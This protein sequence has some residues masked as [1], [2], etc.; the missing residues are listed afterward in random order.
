M[1]GCYRRQRQA[2]F[3]GTV[4]KG[5]DGGRSVGRGDGKRGWRRIRVWRA[6]ASRATC[7]CFYRQSYAPGNLFAYLPY[8]PTAPI[9]ASSKLRTACRAFVFLHPRCF[10][11]SSRSINILSPFFARPPRH[12]FSLVP[13]FTRS[14]WFARPFFASL[15][16]R[17]HTRTPLGQ[18]FLCFRLFR[19]TLNRRF[20]GCY[21]ASYC[22]AK[23]RPLLFAEM[24]GRHNAVCR[25]KLEHRHSPRHLSFV[26]IWNASRLRPRLPLGRQCRE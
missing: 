18:P 17:T 20:E 8:S 9:R 22:G 2:F 3:Q 1:G 12:P 7:S 5:K 14:P 13:L 15:S 19:E 6:F 23:C 11:L 16:S 25:R 4:E 10:Y 21:H 26:L 24:R